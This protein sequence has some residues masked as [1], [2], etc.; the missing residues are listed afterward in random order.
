MLSRYS[1][2]KKHV[3]ILLSFSFLCIVM[4]MNLGKFLDVTDAPKKADIIVYLGGGY[5]ERL[6]KSLE[7]YKLGYSNTDKIILTGTLIGKVS[8][9]DLNGFYKV[10][11]LKKHG[12]PEKKIIYAENTGNTMQ[13]VRFIKNYMSEHQYTS[14]IFVSDPPHSRRI[15]FLAKYINNYDDVNLSYIV[16]GSDVDWW[17]RLHYYKNEEA[18]KF[19]KS[20]LS[21]IVHNFIAYGV[22]QKFGLLEAAKDNFGSIIGFFKGEVYRS[23]TGIEH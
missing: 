9:E 17:D 20:E 6:E 14:V 11:Y 19:V 1:K 12:V 5:I 18:R 15:K 23:F 13:E 3:L 4:F 16:V 22:L 21:K 2:L 10:E 7:L 8:K